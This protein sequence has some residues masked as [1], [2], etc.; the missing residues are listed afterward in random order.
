MQYKIHLQVIQFLS[1]RS[2]YNLWLSRKLI[3]TST[4]KMSDLT[5]IE[6][7]IGV[8]MIHQ[9]GSEFSIISQQLIEGKGG[10]NGK[11]FLWRI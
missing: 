10:E 1:L 11:V 3:F 5:S 9:N 8:L 7:N 4:L 2:L 6:A